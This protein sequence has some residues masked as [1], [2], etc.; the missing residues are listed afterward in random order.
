MPPSYLF[1]YS[2]TI[3]KTREEEE[4]LISSTSF[5]KKNLVNMTYF[6]KHNKSR[7]NVDQSLNMD[8]FYEDW[9]HLVREGNELLGKR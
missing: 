5:W 1:Q 3:R 4:T 8:L 7:L 6:L 2:L 9:F